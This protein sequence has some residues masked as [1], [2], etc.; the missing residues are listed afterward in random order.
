MDEEIT[1]KDLKEKITK[2]VI[3]EKD[4]T[5]TIV[6]EEPAEGKSTSSKIVQTLDNIAINL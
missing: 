6:K 5:T 3:E 1:V 4:K 2:T